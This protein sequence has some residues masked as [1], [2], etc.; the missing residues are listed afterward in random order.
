MTEDTGWRSGDGV[1]H[2]TSP[3]GQKR[4]RE[5]GVPLDEWSSINGSDMERSRVAYDRK[6]RKYTIIMGVIIAIVVIALLM[7]DVMDGSEGNADQYPEV[8]ET[9]LSP[10]YP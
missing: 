4:L 5:S 1:P 10:A 2:I 9:P 6:E 8:E 7:L 3:E